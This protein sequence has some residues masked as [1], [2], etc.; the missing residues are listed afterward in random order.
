MICRYLH[1]DGQEQYH[2]QYAAMATLAQ[3]LVDMAYVMYLQET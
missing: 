3:A 2:L 1:I